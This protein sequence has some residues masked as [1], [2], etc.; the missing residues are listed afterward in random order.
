MS[1]DGWSEEGEFPVGSSA[2]E[3]L[4]LLLELASVSGSPGN[5]CPAAAEGREA[6]EFGGVGASGIEVFGEE[7]SGSPGNGNC[8]AVEAGFFS[9]EEHGLLFEGF[10]VEHGGGFVGFCSVGL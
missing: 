7:F 4:E 5:G 10:V 9:V 2:L 8:S 6:P 1:S 3:L